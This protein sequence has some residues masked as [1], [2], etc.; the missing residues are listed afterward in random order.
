MR[1]VF[2]QLSSQR[3]IQ[4]N[5]ATIRPYIASASASATTRKLLKNVS[6]FSAKALIAA[7]PDAAIAFPAPKAASP[8]ARPAAMA[9]AA[10]STEPVAVVWVGAWASGGKRAKT[11]TTGITAIKATRSVNNNI[12]VLFFKLFPPFGCR[13]LKS[14][15]GVLTFNAFFCQ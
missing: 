4:S 9:I 11:A 6:G 8:T 13:V 1:L 12:A 2:I 5:I 3:L 15:I 10:L 7:V 14:C